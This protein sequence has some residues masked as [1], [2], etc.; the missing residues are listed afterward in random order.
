MDELKPCPF[1]GSEPLMVHAVLEEYHSVNPEIIC[2]ECGYRIKA[3][4]LAIAIDSPKANCDFMDRQTIAVWNLRPAEDAKDKEIER[5]K[6]ALQ[7]AIQNVI[8]DG[9]KTAI[10]IHEA[11]YAPDMNVATKESEVKQ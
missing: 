2:R 3:K 4:N 11:A 9:A 8:K 6:A 10:D 1:C 5:L 7:D